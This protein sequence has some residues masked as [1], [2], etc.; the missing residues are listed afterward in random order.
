MSTNIESSLKETRVF[1]PP[2]GFSDSAH[3]G[4]MA[5]YETLRARAAEDPDGFWADRAVENLDWFKTWDRVLD[6]DNAPFAK[7]F[8]GGE[9]NVSHNCL[10]RHAATWRRNKAAIIFEG[11]PG[12]TRV[13][14]YGDLLRETSQF[15][16][17]LKSLGVVKGDRVVLY[18]PMVPE[19]A[20]AML[21]CTRIGATHSIIFG[22]FSAEAIKDRVNDAEAKV[23]VTADGGWRRGIIVPLKETVDKALQDTPTVKDVIVLKRTGQDIPM[24]GGRDHWWHEMMQGVSADCPAEPLDSEH[25]LFIL[26]TSGSTGKPK[27]VML[28]HANMWLGALSVAHYLK[29]KFSDRTLCVLPL[30]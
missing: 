9:L 12:D 3:I 25:P 20:I 13:L 26:Y 21:A 7:W 14:T 18:M 24:A 10:D 27:G 6:W 19:L 1:P 16:N 4:S 8:V 11:E 17:V 5:D 23:V 29:L 15:A 2:P 30:S 28:T 22:G